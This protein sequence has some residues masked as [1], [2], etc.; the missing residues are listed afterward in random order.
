MDIS[1]LANNAG[2]QQLK[3]HK[4]GEFKKPSIT[5]IGFDAYMNKCPFESCAGYYSLTNASHFYGQDYGHGGGV[6]QIDVAVLRSDNRIKNFG[7]NW[8]TTDNF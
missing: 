6:N 3:Y 7:I 8:K 2:V 1:Q 4:R 5:G